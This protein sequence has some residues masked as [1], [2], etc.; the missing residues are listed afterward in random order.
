M[1]SARLVVSKLAL[2]SGRRSA[3]LGRRPQR[4]LWPDPDDRAAYGLVVGQRP[5]RQ[6][7][8]RRRRRPY[9]GRRQ[10]DVRAVRGN[11]DIDLGPFLAHP[12]PPTTPWVDSEVAGGRGRGR[13]SLRMS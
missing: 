12:S 13:L 2:S 3:E 5:A 4:L 10:W 1:L 7:A 9:C 11:F 8:P 6:D